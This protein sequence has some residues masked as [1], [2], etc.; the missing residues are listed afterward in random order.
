MISKK[1]TPCA[2]DLLVG[3]ALIVGVV[4]NPA[5]LDRLKMCNLGKSF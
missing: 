2:F 5:A 1:A 4:T 3:K